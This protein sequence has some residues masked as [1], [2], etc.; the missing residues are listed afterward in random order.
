MCASNIAP[1]VAPRAHSRSINSKR[2][3]GITVVMTCVERATRPC[4]NG[5][6]P[7]PLPFVVVATWITGCPTSLPMR[8]LTHFAEPVAGLPY[9]AVTTTFITPNSDITPA[10]PLGSGTTFRLIP[11]WIVSPSLQCSIAIQFC[12]YRHTVSI[13]SALR[14]EL[15]QCQPPIEGR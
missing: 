1:L 5:L 4:R 15:M 9:C 6:E 12:W 13:R 7:R 3:Y 14:P 11:L 10:G 8:R 2:G